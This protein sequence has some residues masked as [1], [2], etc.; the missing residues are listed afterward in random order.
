MVVQ[1]ATPK[2]LLM[3]AGPAEATAKPAH[4]PIALTQENHAE[5]M[6]SFPAGE[7]SNNKTLLKACNTPVAVLWTA[8][9]SRTLYFCQTADPAAGDV[10]VNQL[11]KTIHVGLLC[12]Q[13]SATDR[14]TLSVVS[15]M[16]RSDI[17]QLPAPEQPVFFTGRTW[18]K[19]TPDESKSNEISANNVSITEMEPR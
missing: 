15:S 14:P 8:A 18:L 17:M 1:N 12:V 7:Q 10:C 2:H 4:V 11:L 9:K 6:P 16:L 3:F 19:S 5:N 13:E